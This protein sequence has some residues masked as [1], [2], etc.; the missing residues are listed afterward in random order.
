M[1]DPVDEGCIFTHRW[2][3][4]FRQNPSNTAD[5]V[6]LR[7]KVC[8]L[9]A[10]IL[11]VG[12]GGTIL[13]IKSKSMVN[14]I[15]NAQD[16][17]MDLM[18]QEYFAEQMHRLHHKGTICFQSML[19][20]TMIKKKIFQTLRSLNCWIYHTN[21]ALGVEV[22]A[23]GW[24]KQSVTRFFD[25]TMAKKEI[26]HL[27][28]ATDFDVKAFDMAPADIVV[29]GARTR[30]VKIY[31][32]KSSYS[33]V[34]GLFLK[35]SENLSLYEGD[36]KNDF[37]MTHDYQFVPFKMA[38]KGVFIDAKEGLR[39]LIKTHAEY[40]S[41]RSYVFIQNV[42]LEN[43]PVVNGD[44]RSLKDIIMEAAPTILKCHQ[45]SNKN[46]EVAYLEVLSTEEDSVYEKMKAL[47]AELKNDATHLHAN[48]DEPVT[49]FSAFNLSAP[50]RKRQRVEADLESYLTKMIPTYANVLAGK[51]VPHTAKP[52]A[53]AFPP[54]QRPA[55]ER[56]YAKP[57]LSP[58]GPRDVKDDMVSELQTLRETVQLLKDTIVFQQARYEQQEKRFERLEAM[59]F[60]SNIGMNV[61]HSPLMTADTQSLVNE[62]SQ[63]VNQTESM[64][65]ETP[66]PTDADT[67]MRTY[68]GKRSHAD[69]SKGKQVTQ[70]VSP[71]PESLRPSVHDT[72]FEKAPSIEQDTS[73]LQDTHE[74][75]VNTLQTPST[76]PLP[77]YQYMYRGVDK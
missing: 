75:P 5:G 39:T 55:T 36:A 32:A 34:L 68:Q 24:F 19:P 33:E 60:S 48:M 7:D 13:P 59:F 26:L 35:A 65:L 22:K 69:I 23:V 14:P 15:V 3:V 64:L 50:V 61:A 58:T 12:G 53:E 77:T 10:A 51:R 40:L 20:F 42:I 70:S 76:A 71:S 67:I 8:T 17:P 28:N 4:E 25:P 49:V 2:I 57:S 31:A 47:M 72:S 1:E 30:A 6:S 11:S 43:S 27:A 73:S 45:R 56:S 74:R 29:E 54:L 62:T 9:L 44:L 38:T 41:G 18:F 37:P 63:V 46:G 16:I 52:T 66:I 21:V